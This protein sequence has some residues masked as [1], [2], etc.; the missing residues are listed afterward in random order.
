MFTSVASTAVEL[1]DNDLKLKRKLNRLRLFSTTFSEKTMVHTVW[2]GFYFT[3]TL[4]GGGRGEEMCT[5][6]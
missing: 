6:R 4:G 3:M 1:R 5:R 2:N